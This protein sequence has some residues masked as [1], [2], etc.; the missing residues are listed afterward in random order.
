MMSC[1]WEERSI[2]ARLTHPFA[3][4]LQVANLVMI[5]WCFWLVNDAAVLNYLRRW[6]AQIRAVARL[7]FLKLS[8]AKIRIKEILLYSGI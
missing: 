4:P 3:T 8:F 1:N 7:A 5:E 2:V 6:D